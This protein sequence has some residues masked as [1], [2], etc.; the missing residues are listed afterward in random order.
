MIKPTAEAI[1]QAR[2]NPGG[3]VLVVDA[4]DGPADK[5]PPERIRGAWKVNA[6]GE[7]IGE[8][9]PNARYRPIE[10]CN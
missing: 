9:V 7:I 6:E 3:W 5:V 1:A 4:Y 10:E 8:F 2:L